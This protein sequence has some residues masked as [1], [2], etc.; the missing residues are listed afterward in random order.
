MYS[1]SLQIK[2]L[3]RWSDVALSPLSELDSQD[4]VFIKVPIPKAWNLE[5]S[6]HVRVEDVIEV[7]GM[8][9]EQCEGAEEYYSERNFQL[10][11]WDQ[12]GNFDIQFTSKRRELYR[13]E[14]VIGLNFVESTQATQAL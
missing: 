7:S 1:F 5:T 3:L 6:I 14:P 10:R 12:E 8:D 9:N 4:R 11:Q 13:C 2:Q